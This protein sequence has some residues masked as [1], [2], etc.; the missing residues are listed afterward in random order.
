MNV[1]SGAW[2]SQSWPLPSQFLS[3]RSETAAFNHFD[4]RSELIEMR[5]AIN[6]VYCSYQN[7]DVAR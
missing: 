3:R 7:N 5:M 4:K 2:S 1:P 6:V